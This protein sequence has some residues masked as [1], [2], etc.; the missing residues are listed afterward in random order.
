MQ[1]QL[2][3]QQQR[4]Q[5]DCVEEQRDANSPGVEVDDDVDDM[6]EDDGLRCSPRQDAGHNRVDEIESE[7]EEDE[8]GED[9]REEDERE[10]DDRLEN[11]DDVAGAEREA[12]DT[13][14]EVFRSDLSCIDV[15]F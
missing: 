12:H 14:N 3:Q 13:G 4:N 1:Q 10:E 6:P 7:L 9:E 15:M 2:Q 8:R 5:Q 11:L